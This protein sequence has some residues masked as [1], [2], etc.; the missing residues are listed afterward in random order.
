MTSV[1][2]VSQATDFERVT[3][4]VE[5]GEGDFHRPNLSQYQPPDFP[6]LSGTDLLIRRLKRDRLLMIAGDS[7]M[8][9]LS[10]A[11]YTAW[12]LSDELN[13]TAG[14]TVTVM[15]WSGLGGQAL[16]RAVERFEGPT[17]F[18]L[19]QLKP[20]H[21]GYQIM[22]LFRA[23]GDRHYA[24][25]AVEE[26][27]LW[28][29]LFGE[30]AL[31]RYSEDLRTGRV[32]TRVD[33]GRF[34]V[35]RLLAHLPSA[36]RR[37]P[38]NRGVLIVSTPV[39]QI[40]DRLQNFVNIEQ[41]VQLLKAAAEQEALDE[42]VVETCVI[43]ATDDTALLREWYAKLQTPREHLLVLALSLL[44]GL[45][46][47]QFFAAVD[48]LVTHAWR[49]RDPNLCALDYCD[50]DQVERFFQATPSSI[51]GE[52]V[53]K[54]RLTDQRRRL[55]EV[56]WSRHRRNVLSVLPV[57]FTCIQDSFDARAE[58]LVLYGSPA[59]RDQLRKTLS[60]ALGDISA[61]DTVTTESYLLQLAI[62]RNV[63]AQ[64]V[65]ANAIAR[66]R[67]YGKL[68]RL[69]QFLHRWMDD[70]GFRRTVER[71][72]PVGVDEN[73]PAAMSSVKQTV[74]LTVGYAAQSDRE[75]L[76]QRDLFALLERLAR[77]QDIEVLKALASYT[78]P[79]LL[80]R[81]LKQVENVVLHLTQREELHESLAQS[82]AQT[83]RKQPAD[84]QHVLD[85]WLTSK[86]IGAGK[87]GQGKRATARATSLMCVCTIFGV[88]PYAEVPQ[89]LT[90]L[91]MIGKMHRVLR[92]ERHPG[93]RQ[94]AL[95]AIIGQSRDYFASFQSLVV[96]L[97]A[98]ERAKLVAKLVEVYQEQ[99]RQQ[100]G[101]EGIVTIGKQKYPVWM[102]NPRPLTLVESEMVAWVKN[103][104]NTIAQQ[105]AVQ[106]QIAFLRTIDLEIERR[107]RE[108]ESDQVRGRRH[109]SSTERLSQAP[110]LNGLYPQQFYL[111]HVVPWWVTLFAKQYRYIIRGILPELVEQ[112]TTSVSLSSLLLATWGALLDDDM[113]EI[114][115][116]AKRAI[117][118]A[119]PKGKRLFIGIFACALLAAAGSVVLISWLIYSAINRLL[120]G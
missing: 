47:S 88:L 45:S 10:I 27:A 103:S 17:V 92:D 112:S 11:R 26:L 87:G 104:H 120:Y 118:W 66:W 60:E 55:L 100:A 40:A 21:V 58:N 105:I 79:M 56:I 117:F 68:T 94:A 2:Q 43:L 48:L 42:E 77:D 37:R 39:E 74:A 107:T 31:P 80:T 110:S 3:I 91:E 115:H 36:I 14:S 109:R 32:F 29:H 53:F 25:I 51:D 23:L 13:R 114:G 24:I 99:R 44:D 41:F 28:R 19:P 76:I 16:D 69:V 59:Q 1:H 30:L 57:L 12:F 108:L 78:I 97:N 73:L 64:A 4:L 83:Y 67:A 82:V 111:Y 54:A 96:Q 89:G 18:I 106:A 52:R 63:G 72:R 8:D 22:R 98:A 6:R 102:V 81:H 7:A 70:D 46:E 75:N 113:I 34:L 116:R 20:Q 84:V 15:E 33:V 86:M 35:D 50:L 95:T 119:S 9:P 5:T 61:L 49:L 85:Q 65:A 62:E 90:I 71:I 38:S 101:G 93:V